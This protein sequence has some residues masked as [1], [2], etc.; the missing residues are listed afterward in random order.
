[1]KT[2]IEWPYKVSF[3]AIYIKAVANSKVIFNDT[4]DI[5]LTLLCQES[6]LCCYFSLTLLP[7]HFSL[8][9]M[10]FYTSL[11]SIIKIQYISKIKLA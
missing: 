2:E 5:Y 3:C 1:M 10:S 9:H 6:I 7:R 8:Q 11:K 4:N